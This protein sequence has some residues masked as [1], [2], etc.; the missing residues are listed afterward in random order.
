MPDDVQHAFVEIL[1]HTLLSIRAAQDTELT[2]TLADHA[3]NIPHLLERYSP[4]LFR[5]YWDTERPC[6]LQ[7]M[8]RLG[9][10]LDLFQEP[11]AVL[12]RHHLSLSNAA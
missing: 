5:F 7:E 10:P 4:E 2:F 11:W 1:C 3:H 8:K 12:E 6:F 9:Q